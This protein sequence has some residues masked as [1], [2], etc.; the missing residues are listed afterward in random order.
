MNVVLH[1]LRYQSIPRDLDLRIDVVQALL[2]LAMLHC[3]KAEAHR[4]L[5]LSHLHYPVEYPFRL[6]VVLY[7]VDVSLN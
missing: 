3:V 2:G 4:I 6:E 1:C 7:S 5:M